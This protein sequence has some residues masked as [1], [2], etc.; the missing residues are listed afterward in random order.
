MNKYQVLETKLQ[1]LTL[2]RSELLSQL[3]DAQWTKD[4]EIKKSQRELQSLQDRLNVEKQ[5]FI[6]QIESV[7][8]EIQDRNLTEI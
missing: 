7:K 4:Q 3:K 2:E 6:K 8:T 1:S 5:N